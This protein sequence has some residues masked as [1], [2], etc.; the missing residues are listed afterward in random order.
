MNKKY[1]WNVLLLVVLGFSL[2]GQGWAQQLDGSQ[3]S[4]LIGTT[5]EEKKANLTL[6]TAETINLTLNT[7]THQ[8]QGYVF[9][10]VNGSCLQDTSELGLVGWFLE[11]IKGD[12]TVF[13][14]TT[15]STGYYD[16]ELDTGTYTIRVQLPNTLWGLCVDSVQITSSQLQNS[17]TFNFGVRALFSCPSLSV[18]VSTALL[19]RCSTTV[20]TVSYRNTGTADAINAQI[21]VRLDTTLTLVNSSIP[22]GNVSGGVINTYM[23]NM[24]TIP[25][26]ASGSFTITVAVS[27]YVQLGET[28]CV[29]AHIFPDTLCGNSSPLWDQSDIEVTGVC[30]GDSIVYTIKNIGTGAM[31]MP[32]QYFV[33]E[34]HVMLLVRNFNLGP[35][36]SIQEVVHTA[37]GATYRLQAEE[38]PNH[39]HSAYSALGVL[40]CVSDGF[41]ANAITGVLGQYIEDDGSPAVSI[42]CQQNIDA[43]AAHEKRG[44]PLGYGSAH[45]IE[46]STD[47]EYHIRFQNTGTDTVDHVTILDSLSSYLDPLTIAPGASSH[48]YTWEIKDGGVL[49]F[50]FNNIQLPDSATNEAASHG[51]VKFKVKQIDSLPLGTLIY[52]RASIVFDTN[53]AVLTNRTFHTIDEDFIIDLVK[54]I[55][56]ERLIIEVYPNPFQQEAKVVL[57]GKEYEHLELR[58]ID[59]IGRTVQYQQTTFNSSLVIERQNLNRGVY[60][61]QLVGDGTLIG[62]GKII[63]Q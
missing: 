57:K 4:S 28:H 53:P 20:Y 17:D 7:A 52:N 19:R 11:I 31:G 60:F 63:A 13:Y 15:D 25:A 32:R 59:A 61:F 51:F 55:E 26:G 38:D 24:G 62:T 44:I 43:W 22:W 46:N 41:A 48:A 10:D 30:Y 9:N 50:Y 58:V 1:I 29:H 23:F 56:D 21:D 34:D 45:A 47:L 42:D 2:Q 33:T 37:N 14:A 35:G 54:V 36:A 40:M 8:V 39:P 27:C 12:G 6:N 3:W 49:A 16:I 18:D 5:V